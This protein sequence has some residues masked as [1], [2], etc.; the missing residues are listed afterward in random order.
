M[1]CLTCVQTLRNNT[2]IN[3]NADYRN[4]LSYMCTYHLEQHKHKNKGLFPKLP[5]FH[6]YTPYTTAQ[7]STKRLIAKIPRLICLYTLYINT[8]TW[9]QLPIDKLAS[10]TCVHTIYNEITRNTNSHCKSFKSY[11]CKYSLQ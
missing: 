4:A 11:M 10:F 9:K 5:V 7:K 8:K 3:T 1:S 6:V 2:N